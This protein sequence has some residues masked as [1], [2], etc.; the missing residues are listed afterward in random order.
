MQCGRSTENGETLLY[1]T[2]HQQRTQCMQRA[3]SMSSQTRHRPYSLVQV[4]VHVV[5]VMR[6]TITCT[7]S[8]NQK[9]NENYLLFCQVRTW[10]SICRGLSETMCDDDVQLHQLLLF[11]NTTLPHQLLVSCF[12]EYRSIDGESRRYNVSVA[13]SCPIDHVALLF[14]Q[15]IL[16]RFSRR[17]S[18]RQ[19]WSE[20]WDGLDCHKIIRP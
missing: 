13:R 12:D 8:S 20:M 4:W 15:S 14:V 19:F 11:A 18:S 1:G 10:R 9:K 7:R 16:L 2:S 17:E 5:V 3:T 6:A